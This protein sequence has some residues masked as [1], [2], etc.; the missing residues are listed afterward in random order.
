MALHG[1]PEAFASPCL[2]ESSYYCIRVDDTSMF[3]RDARVMALDH[4]AHGVND[5]AE[6]RLLLSPYL[7]LVDEAARARFPGP[8]LAAFFIGGG[9]YTLPR[10]W[11][12]QYPE[13][14]LVVAEVDPAVTR[15]AIDRLW[16][17]PDARTRIVHADGRRALD[18]LPEGD[19]FDVIFGDAFH[20]VS[21]PQH[22]VSDEFH[23]SV[24][25][26]LRPGGF[27][28]VNAV[29]RLREPRFA[30]S[31]ASTLRARFK[32]VELWLDATELRGGEARATWIIL[33][34]QDG[35]GREAWRSTRGVS[36]EWLRIPLD[37]MLAQMPDGAV[38]RLTDDFAPVD[39]LLAPMLLD[40]KLSE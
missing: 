29:D 14:A 11:G 25:A 5:R 33:A 21:V 35:M 10:A 32:H 23:A 8:G 15:I 22:L 27:Y 13:A 20:D 19:L 30:L 39:R 12:A 37:A 3:G 28:A 9:A 36:R 4:L 16:Y 34:S 40:A 17:A 18:T 7:A 26:R 2:E 31:L 24:A 1:P 6:P 38:V